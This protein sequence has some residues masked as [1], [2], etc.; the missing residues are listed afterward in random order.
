MFSAGD[1]IPD[2]VFVFLHL[3]SVHQNPAFYPNPRQWNP[4]HFSAEA[5]KGRAQST[6]AA[7]GLG[8]RAC[9]GAY[10]VHSL[11]QC[12]RVL[13]SSSFMISG[14]FQI[15]DGIDESAGKLSSTE[16]SRVH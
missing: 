2:D 7:F 12:L 16:L 10:C 8:Q 9:L 13:C 1:T 15:C 14:R 3:K 6:F 11:P 5:V 4:D